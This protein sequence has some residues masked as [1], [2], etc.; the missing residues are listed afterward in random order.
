[1]SL[2]L[3]LVTVAVFGWTCRNEFVNYDD[4]PY[5]VDNPHVQTGLTAENA[6]WA[7]QSVG[8]AA[9]YQ[10]LTWLSFQLD[11]QI[12]GMAAWGF[13]LTNGL[14]HAA[15]V[16]LLFWALRTLTGNVWRSGVVASLF[17]VH[18][19]HVESVAWVAE[20]KDVLSSLFWMMALWA[21]AWYAHRPHWTRYLVVV[22]A[23]VMGLLAKPMLV[24]LPFVFLLLDYWPLGRFTAN[25]Q[26]HSRVRRWGFLLAEKA[27]LLVVAFGFSIVTYVAQSSEAVRSL[28]EYPL[29]VR[30]TNG[31]LAYCLYL[32]QTVWPV[33]LGNYY[34]HPAG[35]I[36]TLADI[37]I[38]LWQPIAALAFLVAVSVI[39]VAKVRSLPYLFVG[40]FW[41]VG[42]LIPVSGLVQFGSQARADRFTYIPLIGIFLAVVW[43]MSDVAVRWRCQKVA[44]GITAIVLVLLMMYSFNQVSY[45]HDSITLWEHALDACGESTLAH[46]NAATAL[47]E[48]AEALRQQG[49]VQ[50]AA[51]LV[52][53]AVRHNRAA[54]R[55]DP[56]NFAAKNQL[57]IDLFMLGDEQEAFTLWRETIR[58][59]PKFDQPRYNMALALS[60]QGKTADAIKEYEGLLE[61]RPDFNAGHYNLALLLLERGRI[62]EALAHFREA[63]AL[64]FTSPL[65]YYGLGSALAAAGHPSEALEP[66][67]RAAE[68]VPDFWPARALFGYVLHETG[69]TEAARR[70]Y[71]RASRLEP[72]WMEIQNQDAWLKATSSDEAKRNGAVAL[73]LAHEVCQASDAGDARYLDTLAAALAETA[74][75]KE[76][77]TTARRAAAVADHNQKRDLADA[78]RKRVILYEHSQPYRSES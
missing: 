63:L 36:H 37:A 43:G 65:V 53:E 42:T 45:W 39:T 47:R 14:L 35:E 50:A 26:T 15:N 74:N 73:V 77:A 3:V 13:H 58:K 75:F 7:F 64:S 24:T 8:Y 6:R 44:A 48:K 19:L 16:V 40:W 18:P 31:L 1:V 29:A 30:L 71:E 49:A 12:Y 11:A 59:W 72:R 25:Q 70:E 69:Q 55:I 76:A 33:N 60:R 20:R 9:T 51:P 54:L 52:R 61:V 4:G 41:Y 66:L 22:G 10:P 5:V 27:P 67:R 78:I 62:E 2:V 21:Y 28:E 68:G 38:P 46:T 34:P 56:E 57:A 23:L 17:A 32:G